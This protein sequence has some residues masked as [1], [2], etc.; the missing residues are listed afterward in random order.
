MTL[1]VVVVKM[2]GQVGFSR[3]YLMSGQAGLYRKSG[4]AYPDIFRS[5]R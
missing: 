3:S 4:N 1:K 5:S 2:A